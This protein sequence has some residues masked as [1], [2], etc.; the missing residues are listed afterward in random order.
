MVALDA[1]PSIG[2]PLRPR[3]D[4]HSL[5]EVFDGPKSTAQA[6]NQ[7]FVRGVQLEVCKWP[8]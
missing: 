6:W 1:A 4:A 3:F 5:L 8:V 2:G 7:V